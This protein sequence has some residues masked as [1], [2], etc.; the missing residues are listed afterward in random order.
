MCIWISHPARAI[1]FGV[2]LA[3]RR[4]R[5]QVPPVPSLGDFLGYFSF[6]Q[7]ADGGIGDTLLSNA[8]ALIQMPV[9]PHRPR[10]GN[11]YAGRSV[12]IGASP[13]DARLK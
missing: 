8:I 1:A 7:T 2:L 11:T 3:I 4:V 12:K 10:A 5:R 6:S 9:T 13:L